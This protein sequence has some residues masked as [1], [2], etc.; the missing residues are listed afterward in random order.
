MGVKRDSIFALETHCY[1]CV[2]N[3]SKARVLIHAWYFDKL[4]DF[5]SFE[6]S[7]RL[8]TF[9]RRISA[10]C[11][12]NRFHIYLRLITFLNSLDSSTVFNWTDPCLVTLFSIGIIGYLEAGLL[13]DDTAQ[14]ISNF[15]DFS[16]LWC[17]SIFRGLIS[18]KQCWLRILI[19]ISWKLQNS[20]YREA[21][22]TAGIPNSKGWSINGLVW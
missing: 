16:L 18:D 14:S 8:V 2:I 10:N 9:A 7:N 19:K 15:E 20:I 13:C 3:H 11:I 21:S 5:K 17:K 12:N 6:G 1:Q 4:L 22:K